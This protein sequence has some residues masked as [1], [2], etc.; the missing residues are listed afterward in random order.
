MR[1]GSVLATD[2]DPVA[3]K[4]AEEN[5]A[6]NHLDG[7]I[8]TRQGDLL[9]AVDQVADVAVANIIADVVC[10]LAAPIRDYIKPGGYFIC[11]GIARERQ[12]QVRQALEEAGYVAIEVREKGE[13]AAMRA[14]KA[15]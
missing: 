6:R 4:V 3:V 12:G 9:Q 10:Q 1:R 5:I 13:W 2:I 8:R 15:L 11:S 14:Q 7:V